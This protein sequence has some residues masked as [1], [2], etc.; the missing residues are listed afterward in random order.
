MSDNVE[1][2]VN[3]RIEIE[4]EDGIYKSNIQDITD[5]YIGISIPVNE[6]KYVPLRKDE[7]V[8]CHY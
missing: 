7:K 6:G 2:L 3:Q 4:M 8:I 1:F 5:E